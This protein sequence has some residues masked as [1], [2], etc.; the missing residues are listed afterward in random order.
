MIHFFNNCVG[1]YFGKSKIVPHEISYSNFDRSDVLKNVLLEIEKIDNLDTAERL[2][3]NT[4]DC[5]VNS[6]YKN[7]ELMTKIYNLTA[8]DSSVSS[9]GLFK[10]ICGTEK[11]NKDATTVLLFA[12]CVKVVTLLVNNKLLN[13]YSE[14]GLSKISSRS[15]GVIA[16]CL[17]SIKF[18]KVSG[19]DCCQLINNVL[20][21]SGMI[22]KD[23]RYTKD[24]DCKHLAYFNAGFLDNCRV[25]LNDMV[26]ID[27]KE[28]QSKNITSNRFANSVVDFSK[29]KL[30]I[31]FQKIRLGLIANKIKIEEFVLDE[32]IL[33]TERLNV[34]FIRFID[35]DTGYSYRLSYVL[36][37]N[38]GI[39]LLF[40]IDDNLN[41]GKYGRFFRFDK[42][43]DV[44]CVSFFEYNDKFFRNGYD[45]LCFE[46]FDAMYHVM[47]NW[48]KSNGGENFLGNTNF[49]LDKSCLSKPSMKYGNNVFTSAPS[50]DK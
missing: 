17:A 44:W 46:L 47:S 28:Y 39:S 16:Q 24:S 34:C 32:P 7:D 11:I 23:G 33:F 26:V 10:L 42:E 38:G 1:N 9:H 2:L 14:S 37:S 12:L 41:G 22:H 43:V 50:E 13:N 48:S 49:E 27:A 5:I 30:T 3:C 8:I 35:Y 45:N 25:D 19:S 36:Y 18:G 21:F 15:L 31:V 6:G 29:D 20:I 40:D 4:I